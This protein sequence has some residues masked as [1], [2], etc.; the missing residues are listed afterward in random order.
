MPLDFQE[1]RDRIVNSVA[2]VDVTLL[3]KLR[4]KLEYGLDVRRMTRGSHI[5]Y[6]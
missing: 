1:H 4:D 5:E 3:N 6:F 2:Q